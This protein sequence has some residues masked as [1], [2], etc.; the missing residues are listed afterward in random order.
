[1]GI[2]MNSKTSQST[3]YGKNFINR[4]IRSEIKKKPNS[5][6]FTTGEAVARVMC[7]LEDQA[8]EVQMSWNPRESN[9]NCKRFRK[10]NEF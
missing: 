2:V 9:S 4:T 5:T 3:K 10:H 1:M 6:L 8:L 7:M